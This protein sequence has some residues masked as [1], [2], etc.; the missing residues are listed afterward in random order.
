LVAI[1]SEKDPI[2]SSSEKL[3]L[4]RHVKKFVEYDPPAEVAGGG[5][6]ECFFGD[7]MT[8]KRC[9]GLSR[10]HE[11]VEAGVK[12]SE[13][14]QHKW[15]MIV[16]SVA[17][18]P[19][20]CCLFGQQM[21]NYM[22]TVW[23]AS[24]VL[25]RGII[26]PSFIHQ[27]RD[28]AVYEHM[29]SSGAFRRQVGVD[30]VLAYRENASKFHAILGTVPVAG[31]RL[32]DL[33]EWTTKGERGDVVSFATNKTFWA[34]TGGTINVLIV[35]DAKVIGGQAC[36]DA[37]S[38]TV[39]EC[40]TLDYDDGP[41]PRYIE[42]FGRLHLVKKVKCLPYTG[43][44]L[45]GQ[46]NHAA[47]DPADTV[48]ALALHN[49]HINALTGG[50]TLSVDLPEL[51]YGTRSYTGQE[52]WSV[53]EGWQGLQEDWFSILRRFRPA[54]AVTRAMTALLKQTALEKIQNYVGVH[55][56]R[57]DRGHPEMDAVGDFKD[58]LV[59]S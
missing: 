12:A 45:R 44:D 10:A 25:D 9:L 30:G 31:G 15:V 59:F 2:K 56:R 17:K 4:W 7:D 21:I 19:V 54:D 49:R 40:K 53:D 3:Q 46:M 11:P 34:A 29:K 48:V 51:I 57:G 8:G 22:E 55:W 20:T 58:T 47:L 18:F 5:E 13:F 16:S 6:D 38:C 33:Q 14:N 35:G 39:H 42:F 52:L 1:A 26:E 23:L 28:D 41:L 24:R 37:G 43:K 36:A 50:S 32:F 27:A